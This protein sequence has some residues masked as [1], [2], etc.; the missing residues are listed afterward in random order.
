MRNVSPAVSSV[1]NDVEDWKQKEEQALPY[2][3]VIY[4]REKFQKTR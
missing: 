2:L 1:L 3:L 4:Y